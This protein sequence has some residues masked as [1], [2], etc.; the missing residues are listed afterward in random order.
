MSKTAALMLVL[1]FL[2]AQCTSVTAPVW[3]SADAVEDSW[4][5]KAPMQEARTGLGVA[6]VD[7]KIYAIG[8]SNSSGFM[9]SIPGSAVLFNSDI[10]GITS[11]NEEYDP[12]TDT[13]ATATDLPTDRYNFGIAVVNDTLYVIGGHTYSIP[14]GNY[15]PS[16]VNE[17]YTPIG[18]GT[19]DPAPSP[20]P[21]ASSSPTSSQSPSPSS[22]N[23][24][25]EL[26][27]AAAAAAAAITLIIITAAAVALKKRHKLKT[28]PNP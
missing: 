15:A 1:V 21:T 13:W 18:Y 8:G 5:S 6:T 11:I 28:K 3:A 16:A 26:I 2:T 7:G 24:Q 20:S 9:P 4:V 27:Y 14:L 12:A 23:Q 17:Q 25:P 10:D 22:S 19:P